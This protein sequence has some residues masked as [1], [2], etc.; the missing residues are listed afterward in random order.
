MILWCV[1][2]QERSRTGPVLTP[3]H[4]ATLIVAGLNCPRFLHGCFSFYIL[5]KKK[6]RFQIFWKTKSTSVHSTSPFLITACCL[7]GPSSCLLLMQWFLTAWNHTAAPFTHRHWMNTLVFFFVFIK[8][9]PRTSRFQKAPS[10][11]TC[12]LTS[13]RGPSWRLRSIF[14]LVFHSG[15]PCGT[16]MFVACFIYP[17]IYDFSLRFKLTFYFHVK[18]KHRSSSLFLR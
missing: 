5:K 14:K 11:I 8:T 3:S 9:K 7:H 17:I 18:K 10:Y 4:W 13:R 15:T 2:E 12:C 6:C 16:E 1:R